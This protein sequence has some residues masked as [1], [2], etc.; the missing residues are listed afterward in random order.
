MLAELA[1]KAKLTERVFNESP[2]IH[3]NP[4]QGAMYSFPRM[5]LPPRAV[6]RAQVRRP[7]GGR[8]GGAKPRLISLP[9]RQPTRP[10]QELGLAPD[11]FFCMSLL[12]E[13][14]ICVVPGSGFGQREGTYHFRYC[15]PWAPGGGPGRGGRASEHGTGWRQT[16]RRPQALASPMCPDTHPGSRPC[17]DV[18]GA[19]FLPRR[20]DPP[21]RHHCSLRR[22]G[23]RQ[24]V[25]CT[26]NP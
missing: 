11:M 26:K 5:Q 6:Q 24:L 9:D 16:R 22:P 19:C 25:R 1:A 8:A 21:R 17:P 3:C 23:S 20:P 10:S 4:V 2:G 7:L 18:P 14:G 13:T 12:E 15:V